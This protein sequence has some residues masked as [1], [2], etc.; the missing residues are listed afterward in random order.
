MSDNKHRILIVDND[1]AITWVLEKAFS[2]ENYLA[3]VAM[4]VK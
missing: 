4:N 1:K 3:D 2:D